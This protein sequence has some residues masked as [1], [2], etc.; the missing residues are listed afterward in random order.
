M[1]EKTGSQSYDRKKR[2]IMSGS[3]ESVR[4]SRDEKTGSQNYDRKKR[5][6]KSGRQDNVR[7]SRDEKTGSQMTTRRRGVKRQ[8]GRI[9]TGKRGV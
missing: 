5:A 2:A 3:Q 1:D 7:Q 8:A 9:K 6:I 4:Q